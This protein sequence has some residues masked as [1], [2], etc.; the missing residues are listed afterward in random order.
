MGGK[1]RVQPPDQRLF[2]FW[3]YDL[4]PYVLGAEVTK[5]V[6]DGL[7]QAKGYQTYCFKPLRVVLLDEGTELWSKLSALREEHRRAIDDINQSFLA[8]AEELFGEKLK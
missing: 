7:V 4:F 8:R 3:H 6:S 5:F 1:P 2:A